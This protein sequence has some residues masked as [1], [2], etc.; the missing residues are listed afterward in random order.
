M[1]Q[2]IQSWS[3]PQRDLLFQAKKT[4]LKTQKKIKRPRCAHPEC[5]KLIGYIGYTCRCDKTF[6]AFHRFAKEHNCT[7]DFKTLE[8]EN[9]AK[10]NGAAIGQKLK[11][12]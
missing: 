3:Q 9:L 4:H 8:R 11:Q 10:R 2:K 7:F 6:C 5:K 12:I 1:S